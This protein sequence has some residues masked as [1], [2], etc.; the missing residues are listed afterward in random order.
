V[1]RNGRAIGS[2]WGAI[3]AHAGRF[4]S[5]PTYYLYDEEALVAF[6][7]SY[8]RWGPFWHRADL[9]RLTVTV[10]ARNEKELLVRAIL[11]TAGRRSGLVP[12][13]LPNAGERDAA[14]AS[15]HR[16]LNRPRVIGVR[17]GALYVTSF[18]TNSVNVYNTSTGAF[19]TVLITSGSDALD[20]TTALDFGPNPDVF[21]ASNGTH[22]VL[23]CDAAPGAFLA[24]I[25][26]AGANGL[27]APVDL[28]VRGLPEPDPWIGLAS[29][30][31][32]LVG[33]PQ[34]RREAA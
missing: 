24:A 30:A 10:R 12:G 32:L 26:A 4:S 2:C 16:T 11:P 18:F 5:D 21:V 22:S 9:V 17:R 28:A 34:R 13:V 3:A 25:V 15:G 6:T 31:L 14:T 27:N 19:L 20:G 1:R 7:R 29:G 23:R 8:R 33:L